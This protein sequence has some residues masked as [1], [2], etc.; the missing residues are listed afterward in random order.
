MNNHKE[1][2]MKLSCFPRLPHMCFPICISSVIQE[3]T[4]ELVRVCPFHDCHTSNTNWN[5]SKQRI[6]VIT[7]V[8]SLVHS[9]TD[10]CHLRKLDLSEE[11]GL[12][13]LRLLEESVE[14]RNGVN[15][16]YQIIKI[17]EK[18]ARDAICMCLTIMS[19]SSNDN[20]LS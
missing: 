8:G 7:S 18:L 5:V 14:Q 3:C 2:I 10:A 13:A 4:R 9:D 1:W 16:K 6:L 11:L 17:H 12:R 20:I 19:N 15:C